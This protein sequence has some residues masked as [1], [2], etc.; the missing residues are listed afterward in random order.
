MRWLRISVYI[1]ATITTLFYGAVTIVLLVYETPRNSSWSAWE[2]NPEQSKS[3]NVSIPTG[4]VGLAIDTFLLLLPIPA[5]FKLEMPTRRKFG[6]LV[7]FMT[8]IL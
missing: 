5:V 6:V 1:G 4:A 3:V 8:G 7:I 2:L